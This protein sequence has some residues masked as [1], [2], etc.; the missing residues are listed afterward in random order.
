M[1]WVMITFCYTFHDIFYSFRFVQTRVSFRSSDCFYVTCQLDSV[2]DLVV[3][4]QVVRI[5]YNTSAELLEQKSHFAKLYSVKCLSS[6]STCLWKTNTSTVPTSLFCSEC[7]DNAPVSNGSSIG[8]REFWWV[9][10]YYSIM[11]TT[12]RFRRDLELIIV[13]SIIKLLLGMIQK[14]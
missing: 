1:S 13:Q 11:L 10:N 12:S 8:T 3:K 6:H 4:S 5:S 9:I 7:S 14:E 2:F